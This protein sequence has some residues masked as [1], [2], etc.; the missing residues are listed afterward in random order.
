MRPILDKIG[1][2]SAESFGAEND[3][4]ISVNLI[5]FREFFRMKITHASD[6]FNDSV[7]VAVIFRNENV[8]HQDSSDNSQYIDPIFRVYRPNIQEDNIPGNILRNLRRDI[9][10][11]RDGFTRGSNEALVGMLGKQ[12]PLFLVP[13][14]DTNLQEVSS[15]YTHRVRIYWSDE[16]GWWFTSV[17]DSNVVFRF[18]F[19]LPKKLF[20]LY[21]E[22]GLLSQ[23]RALEMKADFMDEIEAVVL[24]DK[25]PRIIRFLLDREWI[26][27]L[28]KFMR[29]E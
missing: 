2:L 21:Q 24:I 8:Y 26:D 10:A 20:E 9:D 11:I 7:D 15:K 28:R 6:E 4:K 5:N 22:Q 16:E 19:D 17:P 13:D 1:S 3:N 18:S 14:R 25:E 23:A 12:F 29:N 27:E